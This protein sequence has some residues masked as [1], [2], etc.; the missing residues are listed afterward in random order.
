M[1]KDN[2]IRDL[3]GVS[4]EDLALLLNVTR[5]QL[6][7][8]ESGKRDLPVAAK[9]KLATMLKLLQES[10]SQKTVPEPHVKKQEQLSENWI[11]ELVTINKI[12][13]MALEKKIKRI[14]KKY[15]SNL[16]ILKLMTQLEQQKDKKTNPESNLIKSIKAKAIL[17]LEKNGLHVQ[18]HH[19]IIRAT[20][21]EEAKQL[22]IFLQKHR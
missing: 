11:K 18:T 20:L 4:Q 19:Y 8:Y 3:L 10:A 22:E 9:V 16:T 14:E 12:R 6:A 7:M 13:Q 5:S 2:A 1:K 15:A 21:Q 17:D